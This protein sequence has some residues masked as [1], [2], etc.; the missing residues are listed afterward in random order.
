MSSY[1]DY[2]IE[3]TNLINAIEAFSDLEVLPFPH[4]DRVEEAENTAESDS[5]GLIFVYIGGDAQSQTGTI[6]DA[7]VVIACRNLRYDSVS[8][9]KG[10]FEYIADLKEAFPRSKDYSFNESLWQYRSG[11]FSHENNGIYYW[12]VEL[13][14]ERLEGI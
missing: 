2:A 14:G 8:L 4:A 13:F 12:I 6:I 7:V 11:R 9:R 1:I 5:H 3:E 10:C